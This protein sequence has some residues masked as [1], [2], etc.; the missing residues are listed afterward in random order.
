MVQLPPKELVQRVD[1]SFEGNTSVPV[2]AAAVLGTTP[3]PQVTNSGAVD[4]YWGL[5]ED[6][7]IGNSRDQMRR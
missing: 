7:L 5:A 4:L 3:R 1:A 6:R 2:K